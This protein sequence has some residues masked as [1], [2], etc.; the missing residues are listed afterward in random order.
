MGVIA[1]WSSNCFLGVHRQFL[2]GSVG[3]VFT[4]S[5]FGA[6]CNFCKSKFKVKHLL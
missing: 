1:A 5:M 4:A 3:G 6:T 2:N